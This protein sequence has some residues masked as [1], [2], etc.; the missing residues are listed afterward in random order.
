MK[1]K[2][3]GNEAN[4]ENKY[5]TVDDILGEEVEITENITPDLD[6][7]ETPPSEKGVYY[8][9]EIDM[10]IKHDGIK[11]LHLTRAALRAI[12][13]A[14][15]GCPTLQGQKFKMHRTGAG[16]AT[17]Y[18]VQYLGKS[19]R[20]YTTTPATPVT[21]VTPISP[22]TPTTP[23]M[24]GVP[25]PEPS[26]LVML[27]KAPAGLEDAAFWKLASRD[28]SDLGIVMTQVETLKREGKI[29]NVGGMWRA[30]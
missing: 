16:Y 27:K 24:R 18:T 21:P 3:I 1:M 22:V 7:R 30:T 6:I 2:D 25:V 5:Y 14:M 26:V 10:E 28:Q 19:S 17:K 11:D 23:T 20:S 29:V 9:M 8:C 12:V 4:H 13:G 15:P